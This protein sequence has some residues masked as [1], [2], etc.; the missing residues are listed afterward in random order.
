MYQRKPRFSSV[1]GS[2]ISLPGETV[3]R[4]WQMAHVSRKA[5]RSI[6]CRFQA[7]I[8]E[9]YIGP[10]P[11]LCKVA[12]VA[13]PKR[14]ARWKFSN[15]LAE[16]FDQTGGLDM[17]TELPFRTVPGGPIG[18]GYGGTPSNLPRFHEGLLL[19]LHLWAM[20]PFG[21]SRAGPARNRAWGV[22]GMMGGSLRAIIAP[23][24]PLAAGSRLGPYEIVAPIGAGGMGEVYKARDTRLDRTVAVK[25]LKDEF[26]GR[27]EREARAI[28]ALN[29][30]N[31]CQLYDVGPS[32]LVMEF[33]EGETVAA[34]LKTRP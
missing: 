30:P 17:P 22:T 14:S 24:M 8:A 4:A 5:N 12:V 15:L 3:S 33:I 10:C 27:F 31:I 1:G 32:Y 19:G 2:T 7:I 23:N 28:A 29:H 18:K 13:T 9:Y 6:E 20:T 16:A 34:Q 21:R 25:V 26:S 11:E